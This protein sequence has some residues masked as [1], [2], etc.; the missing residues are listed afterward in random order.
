MSKKIIK[1][2]VGFLIGALCIALVFGGARFFYSKEV[3]KKT[4]DRT[5]PSVV[6]KK[7][8]IYSGTNEQKSTNQS[9]ETTHE[10]TR[11]KPEK[12]TSEIL[13]KDIA[14][15]TKSA[16]NVAY[17]IYFTGT[18]QEISNH[19]NNQMISASVI[20]VF[21]MDYLYQQSAQ[22]QLNLSEMVNGETIESLVTRM[23]QSSDNE[24][25]N[26]LID[27]VG[28]EKLNQHFASSGYSQTTVQRK[29]L[30]TNAQSQGLENYTS[31]NDTMAFLKN[32]Y[33]HQTES[34]YANM[35]A[36]MKGQQISTKIR[37]QIPS[38]VAVA[39]KTGE[40]SGVDNDIGIIFSEQPVII[41]VLTSN[42][43]S[44]EGVRQAISQ[45]S[46]DAYELSLNNK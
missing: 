43:Q 36:I 23:I 26:A 41:S 30:D 45:L 3:A 12:L 31:L 9:K 2:V 37:Q 10:S 4:K 34:P 25:T 32:A 40:L 1:F 15:L 6:S 11:D 33:T 16:E 7:D 29:M 21:I 5:S 46:L 27:Y 35:L 13:E 38:E 17:S 39:N 44:V 14:V 42:G 24:A 18:D 28:M 20:K 22:G 8:T 19:N